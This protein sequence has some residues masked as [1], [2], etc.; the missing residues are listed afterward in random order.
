MVLGD[1]SQAAAICRI[2]GVERTGDREVRYSAAD[3]IGA[4][5]VCRIGLVLAGAINRGERL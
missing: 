4:M 3:A 1:S 5:N 2:P